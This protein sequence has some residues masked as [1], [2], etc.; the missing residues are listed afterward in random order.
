MRVTCSTE[1][2]GAPRVAPPVGLQCSL[3]S[4]VHNEQQEHNKR[5]L[6]S[7]QLTVVLRASS[8]PITHAACDCHSRSMATLKSMTDNIYRVQVR[9]TW[10]GGFIQTETDIYTA[11]TQRT[12]K[13]WTRVSSFGCIGHVHGPCQQA[14]R[15]GGQEVFHALVGDATVHVEIQLEHRVAV[16]VHIRTR[17]A[18]L[19]IPLVDGT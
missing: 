8:L 4:D 6:L 2:Y 10:R 9:D 19:E 15:H 17:E 14:L 18:F 7:R 13:R 1:G 16:T 3:H 5:R 12:W 11:G